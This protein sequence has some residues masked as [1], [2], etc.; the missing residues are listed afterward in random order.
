MLAVLALIGSPGTPGF[1]ARLAVAHLTTLTFAFLPLW[2]LALLAET[3][4][5]AALLPAVFR[6]TQ[7]SPEPVDL[8][9]AA[10]LLIAA[11]LLAVPLLIWG[12]Q[13][14]FLASFAGWSV[15]DPTYQP[16]LV[17]LQQVSP[18]VW[19]SLLLPWAAGA[20]LAWG[21]ERLLAGLRGG[22]EVVS[23]VVSLEW[24]YGAQ[25]PLYSW[26]QHGLFVLFGETIFALALVKNSF[27]CLTYL[28]M[29]HLLRNHYDRESAGLATL[30]LLLL[31][32]IGWESQRALSHSVLATAMASLTLL[33][34]F[35]LI[36]TRNLWL[37]FLF[38]VAVALGILCKFN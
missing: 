7:P 20:L 25:P 33:L 17:Q 38:G 12:L 11:V 16:L 3:L 31:P 2:V 10:R 27:L 9:A 34:F 1:P 18:V 37:Y 24:G 29:F 4:L 6:R 32:Q 5:V 35:R 23:H 14:P 36:A 21:R 28:A 30:S 22:Q 26:I 8:G 15:E 19:I 13:P